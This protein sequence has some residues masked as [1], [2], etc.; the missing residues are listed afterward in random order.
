M[1]GF[2]IGQ[3]ARKA[4]VG[5]ETIRFYERK[6][7]I[8]K[9]KR[10]QEGYRRYSPETVARI[11]FLRQAKLLG[12]TLEEAGELLALRVEAENACELVRESAQAK[13]ESVKARI[14]EL[15]AVRA[16][17]EQLISACEQRRPTGPC[18]ILE[19]LDKGA[20]AAETGETPDPREGSYTRR[21][22]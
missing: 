3:L 20:A 18:P 12:F 9:P 10:P 16:A 17:L 19:A 8:E 4:G 5:V 15:E 6:G 7:L 13:L 11:R 2:T 21:L 22:K 14:R 1:E